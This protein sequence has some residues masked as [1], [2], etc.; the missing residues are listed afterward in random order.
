MAQQRLPT[1]VNPLTGA[2]LRV[3]V[4]PE[5]APAV[6]VINALLE[7]VMP[8]AAAIVTVLVALAVT[9]PVAS[10]LPVMVTT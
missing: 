2:T 5:V 1:P 9:V 6:T 10:S 8:G 7:S 3:E 4:F